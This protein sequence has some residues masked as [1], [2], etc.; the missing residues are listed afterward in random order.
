MS[1]KYFEYN[2]NPNGEKYM[3]VTME[4][5]QR[6]VMETEGR[7]YISFGTS[8]LECSYEDYKKEEKRKRHVR[9]ISAIS[10][11]V[12]PTFSELNDRTNSSEL[13][14]SEE[15]MF[16]QVENNLFYEKVMKYI[17][18]YS[19]EDQKIFK[20]VVIYGKTKEEASKAVGKTRQS[21]GRKIN[22][23]IDNINKHFAK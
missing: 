4:E 18:K 23:M 5:F 20:I 11:G 21:T 13:T 22:L 15:E 16:E 8:V 17:E 9:Y 3:E 12:Y 2:T 1:V 14:V 10:D 19:Q 6:D 7:Y